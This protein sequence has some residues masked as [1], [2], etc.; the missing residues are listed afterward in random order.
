MSFSYKSYVSSETQTYRP[1]I[2]W[3]KSI[4]RPVFEY[5]V[6][7][8]LLVAVYDCCNCNVYTAA[9]IMLAWL[10]KCVNNTVPAP[11]GTELQCVPEDVHAKDISDACHE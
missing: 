11:S 9:Y 4:K 8:W 7:W 3:T 2:E 1:E 10:Q 6:T 5:T